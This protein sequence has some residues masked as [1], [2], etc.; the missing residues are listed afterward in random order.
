[1]KVGAGVAAESTKA[2]VEHELLGAAGAIPRAGY[3]AGC[4]DKPASSDTPPHEG[5]AGRRGEVKPP[6][7]RE[8]ESGA[9]LCL[10]IPSS[11]C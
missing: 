5:W 3:Q 6:P 8:G 2:A 1:M 10:S 7:L 9:A 4:E 11:V